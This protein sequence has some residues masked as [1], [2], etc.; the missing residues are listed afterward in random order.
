MRRPATPP[1]GTP[2]WSSWRQ[3]SAAAA[4]ERWIARWEQLLPAYQAKLD[5]LVT[6]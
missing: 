2:T 6:V 1:A 4:G 5:E 3:T